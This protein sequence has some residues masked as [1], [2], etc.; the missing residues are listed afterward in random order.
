MML[1]DLSVFQPQ[2]KLWGWPGQ[3]KELVVEMERGGWIEKIFRRLMSKKVMETW[4]QK[5]QKDAL[6]IS[7]MS[8]G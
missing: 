5:R 2:L 3:E 8:S 6:E 7:Q 4:G 1:S